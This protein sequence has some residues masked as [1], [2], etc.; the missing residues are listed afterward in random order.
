[1]KKVIGLALSGVLVISM[2]SIFASIGQAEEIPEA[3]TYGIEVHGRD[4]TVDKS[5]LFVFKEVNPTAFETV[6]RLKY[7]SNLRT[8]TV[9]LT[10][11]DQLM[12]LMETEPEEAN[13]YTIEKY[14]DKP[15]IIRYFGDGAFTLSTYE[16]GKEEEYFDDD[17]CN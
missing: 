13:V 1:M 14:E 11:E 17:P 6:P 16:P 4:V 7:L 8:K 10:P 12:L 15:M 2:V 3:P 9:T 5:D